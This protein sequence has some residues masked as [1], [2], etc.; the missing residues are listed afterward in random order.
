M[1]SHFFDFLLK[2]IAKIELVLIGTLH[3]LKESELTLAV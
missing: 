1:I 2:N 3:T